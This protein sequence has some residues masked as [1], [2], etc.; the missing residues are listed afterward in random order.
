M[1]SNWPGWIGLA[2]VVALSG[3]TT[4]RL[5]EAAENAPAK[6]EDPAAPTDY[7]LPELAPDALVHDGERFW[8]KPII[9]VVADYTF[10]EQDDPSLAQVDEQ[11]DSRDLRAA[12]LGLALRSKSKLPWEVF[13][14]VD[15]QEPR[16]REDQVFQLYDLRLRLPIGPVNVD[17][18]K[19]KQPFAF[20]IVGL[21]ILYPQQERILSP[22]F[23]TRSIGIK[24]SGQLA[25]DR[26]TWA[27][28]WFNDWLESDS[29]FSENANDYVARITGLVRASPDNRDYLHLG[30]GVRRAGPDVGTLRLSGR[31]ESNVADRYVDTGDFSA[32][33]VNEV[34]VELVWDRGPFLA[35][36]EHIEA[37]TEAPES[38]NPRFTGSYMTLSW[39]LTGE[40]RPYIRAVGTTGPITPISHRGAVELV[41]RY[42]Y[43]DLTDGSIDGGVLRKWHFGVNWWISR[44]WKAGVSYGD[45]NLD[46]DAITGN[47]RMLLCRLQWYY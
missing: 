25:S 39:V 44:Q 5:G 2:A 11:S 21:S 4:S 8:L 40:S 37:R 45:A 17:I 38:G 35:V 10:F 3:L 24:A 43:L 47:T 27:A 41:A 46:R 29:T 32:D 16:T 22:F 20:E 15:Y 7:L 34:G 12:R 42:S 26:M 19:Q 1:I 33:Y 36:A 6:G 31:P 18:G 28:G 14:I 30:L 13:F 23:V 9:A